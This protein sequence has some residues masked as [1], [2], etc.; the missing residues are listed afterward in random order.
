MSLSG[1]LVG[2]STVA[3]SLML[4]ILRPETFGQGTV[5]WMNGVT[6]WIEDATQ[7]ASEFVSQAGAASSGASS[8]QSAKPQ[9][10]LHVA[11]G[12]SRGKG[13]HRRYDLHVV[14]TSTNAPS[15][16][17]QHDSSSPADKQHQDSHHAA[18]IPSQLQDGTPFFMSSDLGQCSLAVDWIFS[19][20]FIIDQW[21]L[22]RNSQVSGVQWDFGNQVVDLEAPSYSSKA[23]PFTL[24]ARVPLQAYQQ[25]ASITIPDIALRYQPPSIHQDRSAPLEIP[26]PQL[27]IECSDGSRPAV[28]I[29]HLNPTD[30]DDTIILDVPV[31]HPSESINAATFFSVFA[32]T[33]YLLYLV[34]TVS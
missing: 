21:M 6:N 29:S 34:V 5:E 27:A 15:V 18:L 13:F 3:T 25:H 1:F 9:F 10:N 16:D 17:Y 26:L 23:R 22:H 28:A 32:S 20:D 8:F 33:V 7:H 12:F 11:H 19:K 2:A 30:Q 24:G 14:I 4:L 31:A